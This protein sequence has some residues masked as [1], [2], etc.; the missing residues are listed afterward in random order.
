MRKAKWYSGAAMQN[1]HIIDAQDADITTICAMPAKRA[2][3]CFAAIAV[4]PVSIY[5]AS[6]FYQL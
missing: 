2:G 6:E 3:I 1:I 5:N 4:P